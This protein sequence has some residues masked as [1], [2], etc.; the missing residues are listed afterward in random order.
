MNRPLDNLPGDWR[1]D[2]ACSPLTAEWFFPVKGARSHPAAKAT[3]AG[4]PVRLPCAQ[5]ALE[6]G[7]R[8]GVWGGTTGRDRRVLRHRGSDA[9]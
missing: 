3:C 8:W 9:A 7:E 6:H 5:Y 2:A 4:C 1:F